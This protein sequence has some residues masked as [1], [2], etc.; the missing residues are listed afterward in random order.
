[1]SLRGSEFLIIEKKAFERKMT[2][3]IDAVVFFSFNNGLPFHD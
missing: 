3:P 2:F 1:M